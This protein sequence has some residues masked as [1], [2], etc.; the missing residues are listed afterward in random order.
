M[1]K[2]VLEGYI[3]VPEG[4]LAVVE[5]E[6][7]NHINLTRA[8]EGCLVFRVDR[9]ETDQCRFHVYEEFRS[10]EAFEFHQERAQASRWGEV[11]GNVERYYRIS[12]KD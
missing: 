9:D 8:E 10:R 5:Q 1:A 4:E 6:L 11:T 7:E 3:T 2:I 12:E